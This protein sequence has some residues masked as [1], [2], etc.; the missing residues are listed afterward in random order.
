MIERLAGQ[1]Y[2]EVVRQIVI[3]LYALATLPER[4][5]I[6][7]E[8]FK[9]AQWRAAGQ[10]MTLAQQVSRQYFL[11][12][13]AQAEAALLEKSVAA[14]QVSAELAKQLGEAGNL[15]KLEQAREDAFYTELGA[16]LADAR[17]TARAE[18]E[19]LTRL[20]GLWG[21]DIRFGLTKDLPPLPKRIAT[22]HDI[23]ATALT[24]RVDLKAARHDLD[25]L[26]GQLG[27][28]RATRYLSA[29]SLALGDDVEWAGP[30]GGS[31]LATPPNSK[32]ARGSF[33]VDFTIPIYDFGE[34]KILNARE[35]YLA[36]ANRLAQRAIDARSQARE[37]Y[38]RMQGKYDLARYYT[39]RVLPL[40][41]T[42]LD[43][44]SLHYNGMLADIPQLILDARD[45]I[46]SSIAALNARRDFFIAEADLKAALAGNG[47]D[48]A[49]QPEVSPVPSIADAAN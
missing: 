16:R 31:K 39:Q 23:E 18:R 42:I 6:A 22:A 2:V 5:E 48:A 4:Q 24:E 7:S 28:T 30:D 15:N 3:N 29:V 47:P 36:A 26:A 41:Q 10:V 34:S 40:R 45:R 1:G 20:M 43:Q 11:A 13:A 21:E 9:A 38:M 49:L 14:A 12:V 44:S 33:T 19:K 8:R 46:A 25:A 37:A 17:L 35:T 27:L 32:L